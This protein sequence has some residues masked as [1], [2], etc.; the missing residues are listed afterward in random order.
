VHKHGK[1]AK[2]VERFKCPVCAQT[3]T[4]TF[5]TVYYRRQVSA[6]EMHTIL[7]SHREGVSIRGIIRISGRS[8]NTVTQ[9]VQQTAQ[10]AQM[11]HNQEV[12]DLEVGT[13][14][15]DELWSFWEKNKPT[16]CQE[17]I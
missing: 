10:K 7:Q 2:G 6:S 3:F 15:A 11:V 16:V 14:A 8:I 4:A 5:D 13:I 17:R 1:T 12:T 9:I